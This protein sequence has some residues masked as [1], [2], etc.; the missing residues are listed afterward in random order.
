MTRLGP[1]RSGTP[2]RPVGRVRGCRS[3][4]GVIRASAAGGRAPGR[5]VGGSGRTTGPSDGG[6]MNGMVPVGVVPPTVAEP[7]LIAAMIG[8]DEVL[9]SRVTMNR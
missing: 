5:A 8:S 3:T 6:A 9:A 1:R 7:A 2:G 4:D